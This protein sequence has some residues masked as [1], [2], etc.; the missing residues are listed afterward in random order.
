[1]SET[2]FDLDLRPA[3]LDD[4]ALAADLDTAREPEDPRDPV[5]MRHWWNSWDP[6]ERVTRWIALRDGAAVA[7]VAAGHRDWAAEG[8]RFGWTRPRL[9]P[10]LWTEERFARLVGTG[11][12][13]LR[14]EGADTSVFRGRDTLPSELKAAGRLGYREVRRARI[15]ELDLTSRR[16]HVIGTAEQTRRALKDHGV[17]LVLYSECGVADKAERWYRLETDTE[18]DIPTTVP[19][20]TLEFEAWRERRF[21][22]PGLREDRVWLAIERGELVGISQLGF[23]VVRGLPYTDYTA[24]ARGVRG[25]GIARALKYQTIAQALELGFTRVRTQ[26]DADNA[27]ILHINREMG[28]RA[29]I[30]EIELHRALGR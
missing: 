9:H 13:W 22:D 8:P 21:R 17:D 18:Q 25:R 2:S 28:Y 4:A 7:L 12:E 29:V 20:Y 3:T 10:D 15:S 16:D 11:E 1:M 26:N 6:K 24:T 23:P 5:L 27:P 30:E 19:I 14:A